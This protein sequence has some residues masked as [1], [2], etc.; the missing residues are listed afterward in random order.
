MKFATTALNIFS[1]FGFA[2]AALRG[3]GIDA[4][5]SRRRHLAPG[6]ECVTYLKIVMMDD[7]SQAQSW[8]CEFSEEDAVQFGAQR[9]TEIEGLAL[10]D[11]KDKHAISGGTVLKVGA[12]SYVETKDTGNVLHVDARDSFVIEEMDDQIDVRHYKNR[13]RERR[14]RLASSTGTLNTLVMRLIDSAGVEPPNAADLENDIFTDEACLKST[15]EECSYNSVTIQQA[16]N[17]DFS[18]TLNGVKHQGILDVQMEGKASDETDEGHFWQKAIPIAE[19]E[20]GVNIA[21]NFDLVLVCYPP[22]VQSGW[23]AYAYVNHHISVYNDDWCGYVSA[24]M[25][26]VGH[27]V[28][29]A[30]SGQNGDEYGDQTG[31]M[32]YGFSQDDGPLVCFNSAKTYQLGWYTDYVTSI[33]PLNLDGGV[34]SY[35]MNGVVDYGNGGLVSIRLEDDGDQNG[36]KDYYIGYNRATSFNAGTGESPDEVHIVEK[37]ND[38]NDREGY[39]QSWLLATLTADQLYTLDIDGTDVTIEVDSIG[40]ADAVITITGGAAPTPPP[41]PNPTTA[42]I[43]DPTTAP[44]PNPTTAPIPDPTTAPV[45][46]P[47]SAPIPDPTTAPVPAPTT[48]PIPDPTTAPVPAP[49]T[50]PIP[51]PTTAPV[52]APTTAPIP[53]ATTAPVPAP[54]PKPTKSGKSTKSTKRKLRSN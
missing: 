5:P 46:A 35:T 8:S 30:H 26:E 9:M 45:P 19:A 53:V 28:G 22:G 27:N 29:L 13:R 7:E 33:D 3:D 34:Q 24:Q 38:S 4:N 43:P 21:A 42:P 32:A 49:T 1:A 39:G 16:Q 6:T 52:P 15:F 14:R 37:T 12:S 44:V 2:N 50:A 41:V 40:D 10:A 47:T 11:F 31:A 20:T 25:H 51:D 17:E 36:G 23:I 18:V 54:T 48:A